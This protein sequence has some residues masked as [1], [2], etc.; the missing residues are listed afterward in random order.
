MT[1]WI[2]DAACRGMNVEVFYLEHGHS[3]K[4]KIAKAI[5]ATCPVR[6]ECAEYAIDTCEAFGIW[7]GLSPKERQQ[8]RS[9]RGYAACSGIG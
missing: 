3:D 8:I 1:E 2:K 9:E 6:V 4:A 5:C 7:G